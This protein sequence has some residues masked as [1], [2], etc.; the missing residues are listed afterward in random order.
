MS[1]NDPRHTVHIERSGI[2]NGPAILRQ[3]QADMTIDETTGC[4]V[5]PY[6]TLLGVMRGFDRKHGVSIT[7]VV[8]VLHHEDEVV[9]KTDVVLHTCLRA[10]NDHTVG[11]CVNPE[12]LK[13]SDTRKDVA[14]M[15]KVRGRHLHPGVSR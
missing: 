10:H 2:I 6:E 5:V 9:R 14:T 4:H 7:R 1:R 8:Y 11:C 12:H 13:K 15:V 3:L